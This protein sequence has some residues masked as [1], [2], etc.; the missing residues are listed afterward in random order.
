MLS[1]L[2]AIT[3]DEIFVAASESARANDCSCVL[4]IHSRGLRHPLGYLAL[5]RLLCKTHPY[6]IAH[7]HA[8][9]IG[10]CAPGWCCGA[11]GCLLRTVI[12]V[13]AACMCGAAHRSWHVSCSRGAQSASFVM[14]AKRAELYTAF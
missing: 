9:R 1:S 5:Q 2:R 11:L 6:V 4:A 3:D 8:A 13:P 14:Q 10:R 12:F 7:A